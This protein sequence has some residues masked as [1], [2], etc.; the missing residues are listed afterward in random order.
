MKRGVIVILLLVGVIAGLGYGLVKAA[1]VE[2]ILGTSSGFNVVR[3]TSVSS[4]TSTLYI[5]SSTVSIGTTTQNAAMLYVAGSSTSSSDAA[6]KVGTATLWVGNDGAVGIGTTTPSASTGIQVA[7]VGNSYF[8]SYLY[9]PYTY[10]GSITA[11]VG[12][13]SGTVTVY[14]NTRVTG[15]LTAGLFVGDG[16]GLSGITA[17]SLGSTS[18]INTSGTINA[19]STT[20]STFTTTGSATVTGTLT[21]AS[22]NFTVDGTT[23]SMTAASIT[24]STGTLTVASGAFKVDETGSMTAARVTASSMTVTTGTLTVAGG[25]FVVDETGS[26]TA[27]SATVSTG[28]LTAGRGAFKVDENGSMTA[29]VINTGT[30]TVLSGGTYGTITTGG[31]NVGTISAS[32]AIGGTTTVHFAADIFSPGTI[33]AARFVGNGSLLTSVPASGGVTGGNIT[34]ADS[35][36]TIYAGSTTVSTFTTTGSATVTGTLT[37]AGNNFTVDGTTG[38]MTAA[39]ITVAPAGT[40]TVAGGAFKVDETGSMTAGRLVVTSGNFIVDSAGSMTASTITSTGTITV[41]GT[42]VKSGSTVKDNNNIN[43]GVS[44]TASG[45]YATVGGGI[46]NTASFPYATVAGGDTNSATGTYTAVGGGRS[47]TASGYHATVGG[48]YFNIAGGDYSWAGGQFMQL[49]SN[50][51]YTFV[52]GTSTG[53]VSISTP[54]AF[55]V[56]PNATDTT[57]RMGVGT[58]TPQSKLHVLGTVTVGTIP[59]SE[60]PTGTL[61]VTGNLVVT[62]GFQAGSVEAATKAFNIP[63]PDPAKEGWMLKHSCIESPTR[64][65]TLYRYKVTV[66]SDGGESFIDL[67]SYWP[68]LNENPEVWVSPVDQFARG[69]G[70]VDETLNRLI[71][72]GEKKGSYNVLL[73]GTRKDPSAMSFDAKGVEYIDHKMNELLTQGEKKKTDNIQLI[74]THDTTNNFLDPVVN[75]FG[76]VIHQ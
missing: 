28:T 13:S 75:E 63:H 7:I 60:S 44:S 43:L 19:G 20:V 30:I 62:G 68:H 2:V 51:D 25:L 42:L 24:V 52:W 4:G 36:G 53:A 38:S 12:E 48:G 41:G 72:R 17:T 55:L 39:S 59:I 54:N 61:T 8:E 69:Y 23:G 11:Y 15:T 70:Y 26:M 34:I 22:N 31:L 3:G 56:F 76:L 46:S 10:I 67:P 21:A 73:L 29:F 33:T 47:N 9:A 64:G 49:D 32:N 57:G 37:A 18:N 6:L 14:G 35:G 65:D 40:L 50:A 58:S 16:S 66:Q 45:D 5:G 27:K 74:H 71:V 1:N